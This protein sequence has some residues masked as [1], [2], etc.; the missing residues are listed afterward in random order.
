MRW[1]DVEGIIAFDMDCL[2]ASGGWAVTFPEPRGL[3]LTRAVAAVE[4]I[5]A[6]V[7]VLGFGATGVTLSNGDAAATA[8]AIVALAEA[9]LV[10]R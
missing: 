8:D 7:R 2:D 3:R 1:R 10:S 9:A 6:A 4:T 5:A